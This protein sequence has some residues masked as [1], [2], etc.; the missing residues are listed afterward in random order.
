MIQSP[1]LSCLPLLKAK[2]K[3]N[4]KLWVV[5][6][7]VRGKPSNRDTSSGDYGGSMDSLNLQG[8]PLT[9]C[10]ATGQEV[11]VNPNGTQ[12]ALFKMK[13]T[14]QKLLPTVLL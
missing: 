9:S 4:P 5:S 2:V 13:K 11:R 10:L 14:K 1:Y 3:E 8:F 7:K 12:M 6:R